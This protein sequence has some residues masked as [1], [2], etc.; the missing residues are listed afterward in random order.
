MT[1]DVPVVTSRSRAICSTGCPSENVAASPV[2]NREAGGVAVRRASKESSAKSGADSSANEWQ[3]RREKLR[4]TR[5]A[6]FAHT[7][8]RAKPR[9]FAG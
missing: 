1:E 3:S 7:L 8:I 5:G 6:S 4:Q 2:R 9:S